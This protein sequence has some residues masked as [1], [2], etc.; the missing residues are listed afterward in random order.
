M[1]IH[2][3]RDCFTAFAM[4]NKTRHCEA[5]GRGNPSQCTT[6][7]WIASFLAMTEGLSLRSRRPWQSMS[8]H[9][10][11]MDCFVPRNDGGAVIARPKAVAIYNPIPA[12]IFQHHLSM[13][14]SESTA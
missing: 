6:A 11:H 3:P 1:A 8:V 5:E 12:P 7:A 4:T 13:V 2:D 14:K 9:H 10:T